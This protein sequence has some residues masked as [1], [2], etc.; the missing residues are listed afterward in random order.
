MDDGREFVRKLNFEDKSWRW[1]TFFCDFYTLLDQETRD[2]YDDNL[3]GL[4]PLNCGCE[5]KPHIKIGDTSYTLL[6][7]SSVYRA[8]A[9]LCEAEGDYHLALAFLMC[10]KSCIPPIPPSPTAK[11]FARLRGQHKL[12]DEMIE[13]ITKKIPNQR[14]NL[15]K[16]WKRY[17]V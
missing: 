3:L 6:S 9:A 11:D 2:K 12:V 1:V 7:E 17:V 15:L 4:K 13:D 8:I 14:R 5:G 10:V 16:E